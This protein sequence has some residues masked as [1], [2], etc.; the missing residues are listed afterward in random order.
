MNRYGQKIEEL[1]LDYMKK[2]NTILLFFLFTAGPLFAAPS[3]DSLPTQEL[4]ILVDQM[5]YQLNH[6]KME[7]DLFHEK[8]GQLEDNIQKLQS[9]LSSSKSSNTQEDRRL[10]TLEKTQAALSFD[11]KHLKDHLQKTA[12]SLAGCQNKISEIDKQLS[13][14]IQALKSSLQSMLALLK[15]DTGGS[16]PKT[17][18]VKTGDSLGQIAI[19]KKTDIKTLKQLNKLASDKIYPGQS[20]VIP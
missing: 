2:S 13:S 16:I 19:Q 20:L 15:A 11:I 5:G 8:L 14:D 3:R 7:I 9:S 12:H 10:D 17:Y 6:H 18:T 4:R 1:S